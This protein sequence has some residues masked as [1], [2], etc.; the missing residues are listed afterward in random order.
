MATSSFRTTR[1]SVVL[2]ATG[3]A[4]ESRAALESLCRTYWYPLYAFVR[5]AGSSHEE[6][7]DLVQG[8]FARMLEKRDWAVAPERGRFRAFLL[9]SLRHFL[10]NERDRE[11]AGKRGGG[12]R[13][14]SIDADADSRF[15]LEP[16]DGS[17]PEREFDRRFALQLLDAALRELG[18]EQRRARK[19]AQFE[20]LQHFLAG[21]SEEVPYGALA[22]EL[23]TSEGALRVAVHRLRRRYG[24]LIR[25][26]VG[27]LVASPDEVE[28]EIQAL[29]EALAD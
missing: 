13:P 10:A 5:R 2:A 18:D 7:Q 22:A 21:T 29:L 1:W 19:G 24:E 26:A 12:A 8:F 6:A 25:R 3:P 9:A 17:T 23:G 4:P 11:R 15:A 20:R 16:A 28:A 14:V 27:D